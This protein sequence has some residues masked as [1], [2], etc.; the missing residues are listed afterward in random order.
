MMLQCGRPRLRH[1]EHISGT[2]YGQPGGHDD[3]SAKL[4][5]F[6]AIGLRFEIDDDPVEI[7]RDCMR[8]E[9]YSSQVELKHN[10]SVPADPMIC[11]VTEIP[12][13]LQTTLMQKKFLL[14]ALILG[15]CTATHYDP[16]RPVIWT[17][18]SLTRQL[19]LFTLGGFYAPA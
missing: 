10:L 11:V 9:G 6:L 5:C 4:A 7:V 13:K 14:N 1:E 16:T 15:L 2:L 8:S 12:K 17:R 3:G 18:T 19:K